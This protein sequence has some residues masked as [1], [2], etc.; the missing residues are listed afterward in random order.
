M[1]NQNIN[2]IRFWK[3]IAIIAGILAILISVLLIANYFQIKRSDPVNT[4]VINALVE[5]LNQNPSDLQLKNEIREFDLLARKAYFTNT[6]QIRTGGYLLII[7]VII[8]VISMQIIN[9]AQKKIELNLNSDSEKFPE[10]QKKARKWISIGGI[11]LALI[12]VVFAYLSYSDMQNKFV[13]KSGIQNI[14]DSTEN[15]SNSTIDSTLTLAKTDSV[16]I[17][18]T[19]SDSTQNQQLVNSEFPSPEMKNNFPT[20]RGVG[21]NGIAYQKN[22]PEDWDGKSGKNIKWKTKILLAGYNSPIIWGNNIFLTGS[23]ASKQEVY[24]FNKKNGKLIWSTDV[25]TFSGASTKSPKVTDDTGYSAPTAATDGTKVYAIFA[26]GDIVALDMTGKKVWAKNLGVPDNHYG[27]SSSLMLVN[28]K[29]IIQ[30]D[31]KS[32]AKVIALNC[33]TGE[34]V[35]ATDRKVKVSWASPLVVNTG[36]RVEIMLFAEPNVISYDPETGKENWKIDC[37]YGEVGPS[38]AYSDGI[39]FAMNEYAKLVAIQIGNQPK[40]L[41]ENSDFMSD[42]PSPVAKDNL[43]IIPTSYGTVVCYEASTGTKYWE[44]DFG[45][46]FYSSP[47]LVDGKIYL[48]DKKGTMHI[49][50]FDKEF[51]IIGEPKLGEDCVCTPAFADGNIFIRAGGSLYCVGK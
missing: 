41:W 12:S 10:M 42:V 37:T 4:K 23:S 7:L 40:I 43:L 48:M 50:K 1:N 44:H 19:I 34:K 2:K 29:V 46:G 38:L 13:Q 18:P 51:K 35:W 31:H 39:V 22:I 16:S 8:L 21:G 24:C 36:K 30:Y 27:H 33:E 26:N 47:I 45:V 25:T 5:R 20:F 6:W 15:N 28:N 32:A 9:S 14:N 11:V 17:A 49:F 3:N